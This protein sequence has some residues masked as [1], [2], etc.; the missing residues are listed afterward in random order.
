MVLTFF[1]FNESSIRFE[2]DLKLDAQMNRS[3]I[4]VLRRLKL[5][6][7]ILIAGFPG[8]G[9]I[10]SIVA[11]M[12]IEFSQAELFGDLYSPA[13]QDFVFI[14]K[15]GICHPPRY[16]FYA[17]RKSRDLIILTGDG[18]PALEDV[19]GHYEICSEI[20]DFVEKF[21]CKFIIAMDG[22]LMPVSHEEIYVAATSERIV[23]QYIERGASLYRNKRII[24]L[25]GLLL[26]LAEKR[27][28]EGA[29]L[30]ASTPGYKKDRKAAFRVY[31][32]LTNF[33]KNNLQDH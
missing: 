15:N 16:E 33:L 8:I 19:S 12:F 7:P 5:E 1:L 28:L 18:Y 22:A 13:F 17:A 20:L 2:E 9:E 25:T 6:K 21:G 14:D 26:G 29:C 31:K 24:G 23:S 11:K 10:G 30:L 3:F 32:F 27:G 4:R